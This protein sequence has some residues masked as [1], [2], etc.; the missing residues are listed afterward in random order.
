M[1]IDERYENAIRMLHGYYN[2]ENEAVEISS[3]A[4]KENGFSANALDEFAKAICP[5]LAREGILKE[6]PFVADSILNGRFVNEA[7]FNRL[8][9]GLEEA[10]VAIRVASPSSSKSPV[11]KEAEKIKNEMESLERIF[12]FVVNGER[13][14]AAYNK[15]G[16]NP[17]NKLAEKTVVFDDENARILIGEIPIQLPPFQ[18]EHCLC[19]VIFKHKIHKPVD[20]SLAYK[21]MTGD[22]AEVADKAKRRPVQDAMYAVNNRVKAGANTDDA[23]MSW[24]GKSIARN[25]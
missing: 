11:W 9:H 24:K 19:R 12:T 4:L 1:N 25:F 22:A 5:R 3:S 10:L 21:E 13:L 15:V 18:N 2:G 23:L 7:K 20:W 8:S 14:K 16:R 6:N 17:K